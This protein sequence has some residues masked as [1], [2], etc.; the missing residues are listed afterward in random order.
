MWKQFLCDG[1]S[2]GHGGMDWLEFRAFVDAAKEGR[3]APVDVYDAATWMSISTLTEQS[4]A[5]GGA[6][7]AIPDFTN[8][9]WMQ[10]PRWEP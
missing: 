4:I 8:G 10:R 2:G 3:S 6:P 1:V 9:K 5:M 7:V